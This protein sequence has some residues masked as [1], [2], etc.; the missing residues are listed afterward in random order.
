MDYN[1]YYN[2]ILTDENMMETI[3]HGRSDYP[4]HFYYDNLSLFDFNCIEWHWH[5][6]FEFVFVEKGNAIFWAGE[7]QFSITEGQGF[8]V[9]S[10]ILHRFY[11]EKGAV[12]PNF[13]LLPTFIAASNSIRLFV[14]F[15]GNPLAKRS[16]TC[17]EKNNITPNR[18]MRNGTTHL[19]SCTG[20]LASDLF[21]CK[22][23]FIKRKTNKYCFIT[24]STATYDAIHS[25]K[26]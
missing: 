21:P 14:F 3:Q 9:N 19:L 10:G 26:F 4:F 2:K 23:R 8:W 11:S 13:L 22:R 24:R 12:I 1:T 20:T 5:N 17:Y 16:F 25:P 6:E 15:T 7:K 18:R